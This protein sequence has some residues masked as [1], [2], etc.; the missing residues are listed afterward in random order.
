MTLS[1]PRST[2]F[3]LLNRS[4]YTSTETIAA[5]FNNCTHYNIY[6][7]HYWYH[8]SLL[9]LEIE[10]RGKR[11]MT[12]STL[13]ARHA[14]YNKLAVAELSYDGTDVSPLACNHVL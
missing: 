11:I 14:L 12:P 7:Q 2:S 1:F 6:Q 4:S 5:D 9:Q 13:G 10:G 3:N 8:E